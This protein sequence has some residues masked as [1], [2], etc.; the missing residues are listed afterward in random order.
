MLSPSSIFRNIPRKLGTIGLALVWTGLTFGAAVSPTP[1]HARN[2]APYYTVEL[3]APAAKARTIV[4]GVLWHCSDTT[5]RAGKGAARPEAMCKRV[6]RKLGPATK[7]T[8]KGKALE[9]A[10]LAK[11]N[12]K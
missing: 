10:K 3:A 12:G 7:F 2:T 8:A 11:C 4:G 5:C 1:A 6:V 9:A